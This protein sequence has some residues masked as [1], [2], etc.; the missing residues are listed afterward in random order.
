[1]FNFFFFKYQLILCLF[2]IDFFVLLKDEYRA[3]MEK[4]PTRDPS[5]IWLD[6]IKNVE[7]RS[8]KKNKKSKEVFGVG[9][10]SQIIYSPEPTDIPSSQPA[11]PDYDAIIQQRFVDLEARQMEFNNQLWEAIRRGNAQTAY[12]THQRLTE[13][14]TRERELFLKF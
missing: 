1:M 3:L 6:A 2:V 8:S 5:Q 9:S 13:Q 7:S 12:E 14:I 11:Q 10:A 4:H